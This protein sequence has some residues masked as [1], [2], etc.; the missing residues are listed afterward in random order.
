[1]KKSKGLKNQQE[2]PKEKEKEVGGA[3]SS[4]LNISYS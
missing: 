2:K 4:S 3:K 1:M